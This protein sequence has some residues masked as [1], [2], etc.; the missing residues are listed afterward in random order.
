MKPDARVSMGLM[1]LAVLAAASL[2]ATA[3]LHM[4]GARSALPD[5]E[6]V[7]AMELFVRAQKVLWDARDQAVDEET[8]SELAVTDPLRT[9]LVGVEWSA[10]T[11]TPGALGAK[12]TTAHPLWVPV[13]RSWFDNAG[14]KQGDTVGIGASGSFPGMVLAARIAAESMHLETVMIGSLTASNYGANVPAMDLAE[15]DA[16]LRGAGLLRQRPAAFTPGGD[17]DGALDLAPGDRVS[18]VDRILSLGSLGHL[19]ANLADSISW[20]ERKLLG[21]APVGAGPTTGLFVNIGGHAANYG[22]GA[23]PLALPPGLILEAGRRGLPMP[24]PGERGDSVIFR[25]LRRGL[26]VVHVLNIRGLA[27]ANGIPYDPTR[28]PAP[29]TIRLPRRLGID[30][31]VVAGL[32]GLAIVGGLARWRVAKPGPREWFEVGEA[33]SD[34]TPVTRE[35]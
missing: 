21:T 3:I 15:M 12:R 33:G 29:A 23:A 14:L 2:L 10:I 17:E 31:R 26:P 1:K 8:N 22:V 9:G 4:G 11:T 13:F 19:P 25:A 27:A 5:A 7:S 32:M 18:V 24:E 28:I 16:R 20:R 30:L 34:Q 6:T 35:V